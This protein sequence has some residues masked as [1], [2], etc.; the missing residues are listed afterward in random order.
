MQKKA[1][2]HPLFGQFEPFLLIFA[3]FAP[4]SSPYILYFCSRKFVAKWL[5]MKNAIKQPEQFI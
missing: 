4:F 2:Q 1:L 5:K 3:K